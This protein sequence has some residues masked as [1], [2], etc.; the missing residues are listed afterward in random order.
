MLWECFLKEYKLTMNSK[1]VQVLDS[2]R[3]RKD[4]LSIEEA[5]PRFEDF[6]FQ[7]HL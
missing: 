5:D 4:T 1:S 7:T 3:V 6:P 2:G